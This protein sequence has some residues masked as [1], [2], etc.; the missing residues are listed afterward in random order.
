M[1]RVETDRDTEV[2]RLRGDLMWRDVDGEI[3]ALHAGTW[4]Y[5]TVNAAGRLLWGALAD[6][7]GRPELAQ[8]LVERYGIENATAEH[9]VEAFLQDMFSR[10][11]AVATDPA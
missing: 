8:L 11:L 7:A 9:D 3:V 6:G 10:E 1:T 2:W 4:E 5:L